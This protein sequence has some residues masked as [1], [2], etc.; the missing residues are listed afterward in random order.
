[1]GVMHFSVP[2][3]L[4]QEMLD[5]AYLVGLDGVPW[6]CRSLRTPQ[7][8]AIERAVSDSGMFHTTWPVEGHGEPA[9]STGILMERERAYL[10]PLELA[11]GTLLRIRN[12]W[13]N[14]EMQGMVVA[15][16]LAEKLRQVTEQFTLAATHQQQPEKSSEAANRSLKLALELI[17]E[18]AG[19]YARQAIAARRKHSPKMVT[20]LAGLIEC[21]TLSDM[22]GKQFAN[23]FNTAAIPVSWRGCEPESETFDWTAPDQK[24]AWAKTHGLKV[25]MGP[26]LQLDKRH[27]P[28]WLYVWSDDSEILEGY[29]ADYCRAA[30]ERYRGKVQLWQVAARMNSPDALGLTEEQRLRLVVRAMAAVH[31]AEPKAPLIVSF[32]R[33]WGEYC[34]HDRLDLSPLH[35]ADALVR[36]DLG[37]AGL[38][39]EV[40]LGYWPG[41][42]LPR[43]LLEFSKQIDRWTQFGLPLLIVLTVPSGAA[44]DALAQVGTQALQGGP[45]GA[46]SPL[47]QKQIAERL[48]PML[49]AKTAVQ[50]IVWNQLDDGMPHE[51][52]HGGLIDAAGRTKPAWELLAQLRKEYLS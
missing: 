10:L 21:R 13:A 43:D 5:R 52:P 45:P 29:V 25:A 38:G 36:A 19:D 30:V 24:I 51:F 18:L 44:A 50:G 41:G 35:F 14:W 6:P 33:P 40:N 49:L 15:P 47:G 27:V 22:L 12:Q 34:A 9:L 7:G 8:L 42:T 16:A 48:M 39:L 28:D 4:S 23:A 17:D 2:A 37:L 11:R 26:L 31:E 46:L 32:D 20:L 1:M 3:G